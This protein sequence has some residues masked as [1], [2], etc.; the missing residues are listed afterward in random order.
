MRPVRGFERPLLQW[1]FIGVSMLLV[2]I[3]A[4]EAVALRRER[5]R[6]D[7]LLAAN[8]EGRLDRQQLEMQLARE[9]AAREA[10]SR[11]VARLRGSADAAGRPLPSLTLTPTTTPS[12]T[13]P[14][15]SVDRPAPEQLIALRLALPR[16]GETGDL[17]SVSL[18]SWSGGPVL[19]MRG[20]LSA[21]RVDGRRLVIAPIS[22]DVLARGAYEVT[23]STAGANG[24]PSQWVASY[25]VTIR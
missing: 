4:V 12:A 7:A 1:M 15:P 8:L 2:A 16:T 3:V 6:R 11:E 17:F 22:G 24:Q 13:P 14:E 19:W 23:L 5:G 21:T 9:Q 20:N 18:R 25:Q 10:L